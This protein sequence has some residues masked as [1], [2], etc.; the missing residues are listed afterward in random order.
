MTNK[1]GNGVVDTVKIVTVSTVS[2]SNKLSTEDK[3]DWYGSV[4]LH[5]SALKT[6]MMKQFIEI[7]SK[8]PD[9]LLLF[10]MGDFYELFLED[11]NVAGRVLD[12]NVTSRN[13][14]DVEPVPMAGIPFHALEG[15][16][17]RLAQAG[18]KVAIAEQK[19]DPSAK[20]CWIVC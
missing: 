13:K 1:E 12:L 3:P 20:I 11:A 16:L 15:Y 9:A 17:P 5:N 4:S 2:T 14:K 10:R 7:K 19:G 6:P 8:V 18:F